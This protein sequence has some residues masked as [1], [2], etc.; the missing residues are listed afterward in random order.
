MTAALAPR[1]RRAIKAPV[2]VLA[3]ATMALVPLAPARSASNAAP[4]PITLKV[5]EF[6]IEA[7]PT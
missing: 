1:W 4:Q 3:L 2:A 6:N 7:V 5:K